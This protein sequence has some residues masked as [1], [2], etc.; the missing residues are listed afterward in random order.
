MPSSDYK[1]ITCCT[2]INK[3]YPLQRIDIV[4]NISTTSG[5]TA[6]RRSGMVRSSMMDV[7]KPVGFAPK[8]PIAWTIVDPFFILSI[9][10]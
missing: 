8:G 5:S 9:E 6:G 2:I 10:S 1:V 3:N 4:A 7:G